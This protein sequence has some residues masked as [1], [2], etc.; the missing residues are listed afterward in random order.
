MMVNLYD[1]FDFYYDININDSV[2]I[3]I[4]FKFIKLV[5]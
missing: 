4:K 3:L 5:F 2:Y 1:N